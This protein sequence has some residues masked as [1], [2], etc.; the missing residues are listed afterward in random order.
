LIWKSNEIELIKKCSFLNK[1]SGLWDFIPPIIAQQGT[2]KQQLVG[3][4]TPVTVT[5]P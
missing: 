5:P 2:F 3:T 4:W 1:L